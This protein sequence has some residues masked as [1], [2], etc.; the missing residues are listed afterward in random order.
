MPYKKYGEKINPICPICENDCDDGE[1]IDVGIGMQRITP[2]HC[3]MCGWTESGA[4]EKH[5]Y[6]NGLTIEQARHLWEL[7]IWPWKYNQP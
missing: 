7:Q 4:T 3:W 5:D 1:Y 6:M 2:Q